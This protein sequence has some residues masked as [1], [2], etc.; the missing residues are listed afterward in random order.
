MSYDG[1]GLIAAAGLGVPAVASLFGQAPSDL[2]GWVVHLGPAAGAVVVAALFL[3]YIN[4]KD[5][6][7]KEDR[8]QRDAE[9][10]STLEKFEASAKE[11]RE[12]QAKLVEKV[13][14][15]ADRNRDAIS[16]IAKE[17]RDSTDRVMA[18]M[19]KMLREQANTQSMGLAQ[20]STAVHTVITTVTTFSEK[21]HGIEED[22]SKM[23]LI[24]GLKKAVEEA[25]SND[26]GDPYN[27]QP[28]QSSSGRDRGEGR[29]D[30]KQVKIPKR[31]P[32]R[33]QEGQGS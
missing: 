23:A 6:E 31:L 22:V 15:M 9:H 10:K 28:H 19:D 27:H 24:L 32:P 33:T 16:L 5:A 18:T 17:N 8:K 25:Q 13:D 3:K 2:A 1:F 30:S 14:Q 29:S 4:N 7:N 26:G 20:L 12:N 11:D 21:M